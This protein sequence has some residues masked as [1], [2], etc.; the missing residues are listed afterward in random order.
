MY[1]QHKLGLGFGIMFGLVL[2]LATLSWQ[3]MQTLV[4][5]EQDHD[6][7]IQMQ[8]NL[9]EVRRH[10]KN[11]LLRHEK[12]W[13]QYVRERMARLQSILENK[14][15]WNWDSAEQSRQEAIEYVQ[16]Y[17]NHFEAILGDE[18]LSVEGRI[19]MAE[20]NLVPVARH[21]QE[22]VA[23]RLSIQAKGRVVHL[24]RSERFYAIIV[25]FALLSSAILVFLVTRSIIPSLL[26]G[27]RFADEIAAGNLHAR[28]AKIPGDEIG[29]LLNAMQKMGNDLQHMEDGNLRAQCSRLALHA[30]LETSLEPLSLQQQLEVAL[31]IILTVPFL[32]LQDKGAIFL[33]DE[34]DGK[35]HMVASHGLS[36]DIA[37]ACAVV[38]MGRCL[39]G[40]AAVEGKLLYFACVDERHEIHFEGMRPHGHYCVPILFQ[41][42]VRGVVTLYLN[43]NH[44]RSD[45]EEGFLE[46]IA[47]TLAGILHRKSM[48][49]RLQHLAHHDLLTALPNRVLFAE[50]L[51][52]SMAV[53]KR[54]QDLLAVML[55]DLDRFKH[56]NDTLGH[57][58]GDHVLI[59]TTQRIRECLRA[60]DLVA[61][62]GGDEFAVILS[63]LPNEEA[64]GLV[65][66]KI[67]QSVLQPIDY[68]GSSVYIGASIGIALFPV[69][70]READ[71][72]MAKADMA[73]YE[74]KEHGRN[75]Y[76][77]A[78]GSNQP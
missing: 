8:E 5:L 9:L 18:T 4:G 76:R 34:A 35:L 42:K 17:L 37:K 74:V 40:R 32:H 28:L 71:E 57:A 22:I 15:L 36:G 65:A 73:M 39:C 29:I 58:A 44:T 54:G 25:V 70:G 30:L 6:E 26:S 53:A 55:I 51:A 48:E 27:I 13:F 50:H 49:E 77:F 31:R 52:Q 14:R 46:S 23:N 3:N 12:I 64:A 47:Y 45:E 16:L 56:V 68:Q 66:D 24:A 7:L 60:S 2:L 67:V 69:H 10:E 38:P 78:A 43:E 20:M 41:G 62:M 59:I 19:D 75:S 63:D 21:L 1:I 11:F 61:R 33:L 72:L